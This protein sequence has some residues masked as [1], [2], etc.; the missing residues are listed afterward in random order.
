MQ[1]RAEHMQD[2]GWEGR[3]F[4]GL[5]APNV[6]SEARS[7]VAQALGAIGVEA[8]HFLGVVTAFTR[9]GPGVPATRAEGERFLWRLEG[10]ARRL[11]ALAEAFELATQSY[12]AALEGAHP[13]LRASTDTRGD[14]DE[15]EATAWWPPADLGLPSGEPLDICLRRCDYAYRHVVA[16]H[17]T[18][19]VEAV[20]EELSLVLHALRTL[21]PA[22]VLPS[23]TL[24]AGLYELA[25]GFQGHIVPHHLSDLSARTPGLLSGIVL[26][27]QLDAREDRSLEADLTWARA[28]LAELEQVAAE[29]PAP[30][31]APP[32]AGARRGLAG[33]FRRAPQAASAGASAQ[34]SP[35]AWAARAEREWRETIAALEVLRATTT[36]GSP[37]P[38]SR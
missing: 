25:S 31:A 37:R 24:Y 5:A 11:A 26:L 7:A 28:Q 13:E 15:F 4:P 3:I 21:P 27:R 17:L 35:R 12:L 29:L 10:S 9:R 23:S 36:S 33:L 22:G 19:N 20:G 1:Q 32:G 6:P 16:A 38:H 18:T 30:P 2:T 34:A 8:E 14:A